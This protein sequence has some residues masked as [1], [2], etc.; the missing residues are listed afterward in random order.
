M[1]QLSKNDANLLL[2]LIYESLSC[3]SREGFTQLV[4][5]F[6]NLVPFKYNTC[7][8]RRKE[9]FTGKEDYEVLNINYP[10]EWL[11]LYISKQFNL[12]DPIIK[13]NFVDFELQYWSDT[14]KKHPPPKEFQVLA[15][16][17]GLTKGYTYGAR[18]T[19]GTESSLFSFSGSNMEQ[20]RSREE[21]LRHFVP[22][23]HQV[24]TRITK[25][26]N[27]KKKSSH[28]TR[29][30]REVLKWVAHGKSSWD[31][32]IIL[33]ISERTVNFHV[34]SILRKL[35]AVSRSHA[36]AIALELGLVDID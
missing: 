3:N 16:A 1:T 27:S 31:V 33:N 32:S 17:F 34:N 25:P 22:H 4:K 13:K 19:N 18:N 35:D 7:V 8:F 5:K 11:E 36:V 6:D 10:E 2:D 23:L 14:Y 9:I 21:I 15:E 20:D 28:L 12:I 29:R 24:F 30:E 26:D